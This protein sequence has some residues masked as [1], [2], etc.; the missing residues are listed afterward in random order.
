MPDLEIRLF[1]GKETEPATTVSI[2][3]DVLAMA[4]K[5]IPAHVVNVLS[6]LFMKFQIFKRYHHSS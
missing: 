4:S 3:L 2:P 1:N 6:S 5:L